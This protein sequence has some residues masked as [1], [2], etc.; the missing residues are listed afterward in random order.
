MANLEQKT[1]L[2]KYWW[3]LLIAGIIIIVAVPLLFMGIISPV[4]MSK[5]QG[6][7]YGEAAYDS[8][9]S[10]GGYGSMPRLSTQDFAPEVEERQLIKTSSA[11]LEIERGQFYE[12]QDKVKN[13][14]TASGAFILSENF[15]SIGEGSYTYKTNTFQLKIETSKYD[16]VVEQLKD[17]AE[18]TSFQQTATDVTGAITNAGLEIEVEKARLKRYEDLMNRQARLEDQITLTDRIFEQERRIIYLEDNLK[19]STQQVAYSTISLT[20]T[21]KKPALYGVAFAGWNALIKTFVGSINALLYFISAVLP[22]IVGA[23]ILYWIY[24][25]IRKRA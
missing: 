5:T 23:G 9:S 22:W 17:V 4:S 21:E 20:L 16:A 15:R 7:N 8:V 1:W 19:E 11:S 2:Q 6:L 13:I 14:L 24:R 25:L 3:T 10:A 18:I 12:A